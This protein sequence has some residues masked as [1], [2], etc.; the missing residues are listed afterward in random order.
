MPGRMKLNGD[1]GERFRAMPGR[2]KLNGD[3]GERF[4]EMPGW[5]ELN[6]DGAGIKTKDGSSGS[7]PE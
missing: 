5:M 1:G 2:M 4:R 7:S 6:G 3:G